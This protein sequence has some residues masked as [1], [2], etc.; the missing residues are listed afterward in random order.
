MSKESLPK[1]YSF[2]VLFRSFL[3]WIGHENAGKVG[4]YVEATYP[5]VLLL[6]N[7]NGLLVHRTDKKIEFTDLD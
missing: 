2:M 3:E 1:S 5:P 6:L 4:E 7:I